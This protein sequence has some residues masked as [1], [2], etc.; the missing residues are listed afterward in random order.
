MVD[1]TTEQ[2]LPFTFV[3]VDGRGRPQPIDG[4]PTVAVSD[5]TVITVAPLT[6]SDQITW[7]GEAVSGLQGAARIVVTADS[8]ITP[9][10]VNDVIGTLDVNVTLDPRTAART[11]TL[12]A[13][14]PVDKPV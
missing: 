13:G 6:S 11:V 14:T 12:T 2:T 5:E 8:D 7:A 1:I 9:A 3:V 4:A 10:G